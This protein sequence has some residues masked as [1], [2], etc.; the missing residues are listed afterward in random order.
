MLFRWQEHALVLSQQDLADTG[1]VLLQQEWLSVRVPAQQLVAARQHQAFGSL[2]P[3]RFSASLPSRLA[4]AQ[5]HV[6]SGKA[7][8]EA[9]TAASQTNIF[10]ANPF[11]PSI[12]G[13]LLTI[14]GYN[15]QEQPSGLS[16]GNL[17]GLKQNTMVFANLPSPLR[18]AHYTTK[19]VA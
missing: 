6:A 3:W 2:R 11:R 17:I 13:P 1:A 18:Q 16:E 19:F 10:D 7:W 4:V 8:S 12:N 14:C 9:S 5:L 15:R